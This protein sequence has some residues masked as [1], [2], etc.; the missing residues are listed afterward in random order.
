[1]TEPLDR[2]RHLARGMAA[3]NPDAAEV[4]AEE[5]ARQA[6]QAK[7]PLGFGITLRV[8]RVKG[9]IELRGGDIQ[10]GYVEQD[11]DAVYAEYI[12]PPL[13]LDGDG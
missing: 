6:R 13:D 7:A 4:L 8:N 11:P 12:S 2:L 1:M 3:S 5:L 9:Q 10:R